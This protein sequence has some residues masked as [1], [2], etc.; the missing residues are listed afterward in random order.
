[1][2]ARS[3]ATEGGIASGECI[4]LHRG[5]LERRLR[6]SWFRG[7]RCVECGLSLLDL[8]GI[9]TGLEGVVGLVVVVVDLEG[10]GTGVEWAD[11]CCE[12]TAMLAVATLVVVPLFAGRYFRSRPWFLLVVVVGVGVAGGEE[13]WKD[14]EVVEV[15][16]EGEGEDEGEARRFWFCLETRKDLGDIIL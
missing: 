10:L 14:M 4:S 1:M 2:T 5:E 15:G 8:T 7:L 6:S 11:R 13:A 3:A 16:G 9:W 12:F